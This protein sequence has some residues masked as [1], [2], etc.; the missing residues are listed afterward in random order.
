MLVRTTLHG[1][2]SLRTTLSTVQGSNVKCRE[3]LD[4]DLRKTSSKRVKAK[5]DHS[6]GDGTSGWTTVARLSGQA[7]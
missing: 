1:A 3:N 2:P 6:E 4:I 5:R 7:L